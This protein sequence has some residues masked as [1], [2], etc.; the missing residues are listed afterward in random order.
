MARRSS[1]LLIVGSRHRPYVPRAV[2]P[3]RSLPRRTAMT[4]TPASCA[5]GALVLAVGLLTGACDHLGPGSSGSADCT[6]QISVQ[7]TVYS[8]YGFTRHDTTEEG[9]ALESV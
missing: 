1:F 7:G 9:D 6:T 3:P 5:A 4:S 8:S 2:E